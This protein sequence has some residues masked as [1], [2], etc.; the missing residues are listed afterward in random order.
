MGESDYNEKSI[1]ATLARIEAKLDMYGVKIGSH[2]KQIEDLKMW[3]WLSAGGT[4]VV[5]FVVEMFFKSK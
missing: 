2:E 5:V 4:A 1:D 3:R